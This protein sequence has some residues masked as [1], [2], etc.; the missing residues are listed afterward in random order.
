[1]DIRAATREGSDTPVGPALEPLC[2]TP[3]GDA[4]GDQLIPAGDIRLLAC[5]FGQP[6]GMAENDG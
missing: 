2:C 4:L 5:E 3:T 6:Q 1:M